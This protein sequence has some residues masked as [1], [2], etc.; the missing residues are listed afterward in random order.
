M[1]SYFVLLPRLQ[2]LAYPG[3]R[4]FIRGVGGMTLEIELTNIAE[5]KKP[6]MLLFEGAGK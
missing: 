4:T 6:K 1:S 5:Q 2:I 3:F